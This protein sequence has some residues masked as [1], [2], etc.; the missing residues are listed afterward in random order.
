MHLYSKYVR[1]HPPTEFSHVTRASSCPVSAVSLVSGKH[2]RMRVYAMALHGPCPFGLETRWGA[3]KD[4]F[5]QR[6]VVH[7]SCQAF[8]MSPDAGRTPLGI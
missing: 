2:A 3:A 7:G 1:T 5:R 8:L 4:R 6:G